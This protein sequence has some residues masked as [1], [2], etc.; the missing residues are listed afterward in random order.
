VIDWALAGRTA[1]VIAGALLFVWLYVQAIKGE[2]EREDVEGDAEL[3][4]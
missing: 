3:F 1:T 4:L 2:I